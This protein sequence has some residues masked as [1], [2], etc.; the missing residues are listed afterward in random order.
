MLWNKMKWIC[1]L[2]DEQSA[3]CEM[4]NM[5]PTKWKICTVKVF[6]TWKICTLQNEKSAFCNENKN[7]HFLKWKSV[8]GEMKNLYFVKWKIWLY[9]YW[10]FIIRA[11]PLMS[12]WNLLEGK[13]N[14][15]SFT[16][17]WLWLV[18]LIS[19]SCQKYQTARNSVVWKLRPA[20][21]LKRLK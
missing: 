12:I 17:S 14:F 1:S 7:L 18:H 9:M 10:Y 8:L 4:K 3:L 13:L 5:Y 21:N 6:V 16:N 11:V 19:S 20:V 2:W 15:H